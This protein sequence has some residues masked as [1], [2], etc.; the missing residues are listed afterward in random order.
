ETELW[1]NTIHGCARRG[2]PVVLANARLSEKSRDGYRRFMPLVAPMVAQLAAVA[3]QTGGDAERFLSLGLTT[4][5]LQVT[6]NIKF[7]LELGD[8]Q[9]S[10]ARALAS[11]WRGSGGR[12]V[13]L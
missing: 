3:A 2:I 13:W 12:P 9:R 6:G 7:D 5:Q 1:P 11:Q 4:G 8:S 10:D